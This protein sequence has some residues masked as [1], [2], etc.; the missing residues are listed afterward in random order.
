MSKLLSQGGFGCVYYPGLTCS[1]KSGKDKKIVTKLQRENFNAKNEISIGDIIM[2]IPDYQDY[3][4]PVIDSCLVNIR[5][6]NPKNITDCQVIDKGKNLPLI[7][8][9]IPYIKNYEFLK[10]FTLKAKLGNKQLIQTIFYTYTYIL[11][12]IQYLLDKKLVHLD[13]KSEN[14]LFNLKTKT[15]LLIDFGISINM[16]NGLPRDKWDKY[17]YIYAPQYYVWPLEVHVINFLLH[18]SSKLTQ[19]DASDIAM[20][21]TKTNKALNIF[22]NDFR[23]KYR[24]LC[25]ICLQSYIDKDRDEVIKEILKSYNTWDN[26]SLSIL[27]LKTF[28]YIFENGFSQ[29]NILIRFSQLLLL[30]ISPDISIRL[31]INNTKK[32]F[33]RI[34]LHL[35]NSSHYQNI[36]DNFDTLYPSASSR[37]NLSYLDS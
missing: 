17:F 35:R 7:L 14:I 23:E 21:Y 1:G 6:I 37:K 34:F 3:F 10:L 15:P 28:S 19:S 12:S 8:M 9:T 33:K 16:S 32:L 13:I 27:Y 5:N 20:L 22:S 25:E 30:N 29:N 18:E 31:S 26:Y 11:S 2:T 36:I 4:L 24:K